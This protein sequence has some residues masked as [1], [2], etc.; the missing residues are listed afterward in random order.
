MLSG[1]ADAATVSGPV[2]HSQISTTMDIYTHAFDEKAGGQC[3]DAE[4]RRGARI[5]F[6]LI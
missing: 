6:A 1:G 3:S 5:R 2:G 4:K